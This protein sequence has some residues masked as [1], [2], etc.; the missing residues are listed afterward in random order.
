[1]KYRIIVVIV[2]SACFGFAR[3]AYAAAFVNLN[4]E[5]AM[6]PAIGIDDPFPPEWAHELTVEEL[7]P[8]WT[9]SETEIPVGYAGVCLG[10]ACIHLDGRRGYG[11]FFEGDFHVFL[12]GGGL[13]RNGRGELTGVSL[14]QTGDIP[15]GAKSIRMLSTIDTAGGPGSGQIYGYVNLRASIDGINIPL[16]LLSVDGIVATI[17]GNIPAAVGQNAELTVSTITP[18]SNERY[19]HLDA[20]TFSMQPVPEP[21]T[22]L[23]ALFVAVAQQTVRCRNVRLPTSSV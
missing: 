11:S 6:I 8:G 10:G 17:G 22:V 3:S 9:P 2:V 19:S 1:M 18:D 16:S 15:A 13:T 20:I 21:S 7:L 12:Q 5:E 23:M 14:S 4:F